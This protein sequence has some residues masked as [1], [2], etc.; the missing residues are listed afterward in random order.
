MKP[1]DKVDWIIYAVYWG[2]FG[3]I[4]ALLIGIHDAAAAKLHV[5]WT[6]PTKNTDGSTLTDLIGYRVEWGSCAADGSF[7]TY[8]AGINVNASFVSTPIYPTGLTKVCVRL[9]AINSQNVLSAPAYASGVT[10][11]L[12][13][14][15]VH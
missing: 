9:Y 14:Q 3:I 12:L 5:I 15:P 10:L 2:V 6:T 7:G 11:P 13:S 1:H 4:C 8:Q